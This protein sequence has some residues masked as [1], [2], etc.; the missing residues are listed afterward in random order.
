M[1]ATSESDAPLPMWV[2]VCTN[3]SCRSCGEHF[4]A[5]SPAELRRT[6]G[7]DTIKCP[8]CERP[9]LELFPIDGPEHARRLARAAA[10]AASDPLKF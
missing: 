8:T 1:N 10:R 4:D 5:V 6:T 2:Y 3:T 9:A 7:F